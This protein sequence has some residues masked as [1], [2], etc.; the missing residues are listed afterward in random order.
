MLNWIIEASL[1]NR[2][3]VILG[4]VAFAALGAFALTLLDIDAFPD[5]TP[6]Q[7]QIDRKSTRLNSSH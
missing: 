2:F 3:L 5:T 6:I 4:A 7:V 1:R